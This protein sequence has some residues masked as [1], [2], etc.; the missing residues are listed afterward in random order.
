MSR[1]QVGFWAAGVPLPQGSKRIGR[2]RATGAP[3]LIDDNA[4]LKGWR[5]VVDFTARRVVKGR[6][7]IDA[8]CA[9]DLSFYMPRPKG[10]Y[11]ADG[12]TLRASAPALWCAVKP[13]V[14]K[15]SRAV[16]DSLTTAGVWTEDSRAVILRAS[17]QYARL[18]H[19]AGVSVLV[20]PL[21]EG[22]AP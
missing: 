21:R 4:E 17:M 20:S 6:E 9:V 19:E 3:V 18:P 2:N 11:R 12:V 13:D 1:G 8:P 5:E 16:L 15:L 14:D 10:H 22:V 7:V